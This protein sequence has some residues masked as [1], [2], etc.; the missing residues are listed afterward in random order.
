MAFSP[1]RPK[2]HIFNIGHDG[3]PSI[4][5]VM[6]I[7]KY[8]IALQIF[9]LSCPVNWSTAKKCASYFRGNMEFPI[10]WHFQSFDSTKFQKL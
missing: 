7:L 3:T 1:I 2:S 4:G 6:L 5:N 9:D 10:Y 8:N